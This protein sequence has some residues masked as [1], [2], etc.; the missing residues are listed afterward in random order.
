MNL[1]RPRC[2]PET[3]LDTVRL[4]CCRK[5]RRSRLRAP[6]YAYHLD[7]RELVGLAVETSDHVVDGAEL[8][9]IVEVIDAV[10][11]LQT[12]VFELIRW[13]AALLPSPAWRRVVFG[14]SGRAA[15]WAPP[16]A[17]SATI[18]GDC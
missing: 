11:V 6:A 16:A 4:F 5:D 3:A 15:Q 14:D 2:S 10:P 12:D 9:A 13:A 8:K 1:D 7:P 18:T 17:H